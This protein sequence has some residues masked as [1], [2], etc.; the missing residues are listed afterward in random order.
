VGGGWSHPTG[1]TTHPRRVPGVSDAGS[2]ATPSF[3]A[4][5]GPPTPHLS[6]FVGGGGG[7]VTSDSGGTGA[8]AAAAGCA[9]A[10]AAGA[11]SAGGGGGDAGLAAAHRALLEKYEKAKVGCGLCGCVGVGVGVGVGGATGRW[12]GSKVCCR[13]RGRR[14]VCGGEAQ[15][16]TA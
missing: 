7:G 9:A 12:L 1:V 11:E 6:G 13:H 14:D 4:G 15:L 2:L 8:A 10:G 5:E 16:P 3:P